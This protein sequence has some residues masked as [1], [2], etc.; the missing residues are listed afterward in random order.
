MFSISNFIIEGTFFGWINNIRSFEFLEK[1]TMF[2]AIYQVGVFAVLTLSDSSR[3]D[4]ILSII[5]IVKLAIVRAEYDMKFDDIEKVRNEFSNDPS[6]FFTKGSKQDIEE[7][8]MSY[9]AYLNRTISKNEYQHY[10]KNKLVN[11]EH[12]YEFH[13]LAWRLSFILRIKK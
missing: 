8:Y 9:M 3:K 5:K 11:L 2:F 7:I 10:L 4:S 6:I 12:S 13:E 1:C